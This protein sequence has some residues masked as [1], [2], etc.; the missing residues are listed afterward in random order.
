M[1]IAGI[2]LLQA[3]VAL[4]TFEA[5]QSEQIRAPFRSF[6]ATLVDVL[7]TVNELPTTMTNFTFELTHNAGSIVCRIV[8]M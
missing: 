4:Y 8:I 5:R 7:Q 2:L 6:D 1:V 3:G